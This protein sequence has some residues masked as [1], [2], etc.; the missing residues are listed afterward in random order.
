MG[1]EQSPDNPP[2]GQ[3]SAASDLEGELTR[4]AKRA[5]IEARQAK[6]AELLLAEQPYR[7]I[8]RVCDV[9]LGTVASDVEAIR[10]GWR[11]AKVIALEDHRD[12]VR[13]QLTRLM[14]ALSTRAFGT[15]GQGPDV[16]AIREMRHLLADVRKLDGLDRPEQIHVSGQLSHVEPGSLDAMIE[17]ANRHAAGMIA[18]GQRVIDAE[19]VE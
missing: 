17:V 19:L 2:E 1:A 7:A 10:A 16:E 14:R 9:S 4:T 15:P 12:H 13:A 5:E 6:V 11:Q 18:A 8:A 3:Q